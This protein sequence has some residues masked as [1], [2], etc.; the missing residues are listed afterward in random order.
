LLAGDL[1]META[2][3]LSRGPVVLPL[4]VRE[5][6]NWEPGTELTVED[7]AA[8]VLLRPVKKLAAR[9]DEPTAVRK[10]GKRNAVEETARAGND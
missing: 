7:T 10:A 8:G 9:R 3:L 5:R 4:S 2:K 1:L 6:L